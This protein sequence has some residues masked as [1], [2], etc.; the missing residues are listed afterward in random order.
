MISLTNLNAMRSAAAMADSNADIK[1]SMERLSTGS[2]INSA[3]DDAAGLAIATEMNTQIVGMAK[4]IDN[5]ADGANLMSTADGALNEVNSLLQRMRELAMQAANGTQSD[6]DLSSLNDEYQ[7][8]KS[9]IARIGANTEWNGKKIFDGIGFPGETKFQVGADAGQTIGVI[10]DK[11]AISEL[12]KVAGSALVTHPSTPPAAETTQETFVAHSA[13]APAAQSTAGKKA[14]M[15]SDFDGDGDADILT[16][17]GS[18]SDYIGTAFLANDG[19]GSFSV[20]STHLPTHFMNFG[21]PDVAI[22]IADFDGDGDVDYVTR[23]T[24]TR[25]FVTYLN[26]GA[27]N[28]TEGVQTSIPFDNY[29]WHETLDI[30][31]TDI[32]LDGDADVVT[33]D[34]IDANFSIYLNDGAGNFT[35]DRD[36]ATPTKATNGGVGGVALVAGDVDGDGDIDVV[37]LD[38]QAPHS[39]QVFLNDGNRNFSRH[40]NYLEGVG[41]TE[42]GVDLGDVDGDGDLDLVTRTHRNNNNANSDMEHNFRILLNDGTG[43]FSLHTTYDTRGEMHLRHAGVAIFDAD[44]DGDNDLAFRSGDATGRYSDVFVYK[45]DGTANF[46]LHET[47]YGGPQWQTAADIVAKSVT[48]AS[49]ST[50]AFDFSSLSLSVGDK[51]AVAVPGGTNVSAIMDSNGLAT[52]LSSLGN[53]LAAQ[54]SL[55]SGA[56]NAGGVLTVSGLTDGSA[57]PT[58]SVSLEAGVDTTRFDFNGKNLEEGDQI[59]VNVSGGTDVQGSLDSNGLDHLLGTLAT[60]L[61][62]QGSLFSNAFVSNGVLGLTGLTDG[63]AITTVTVSLNTASMPIESTNLSNYSNATTTLGN[64]DQAIE[65]VSRMRAKYGATFNQLFAA[66][67]NLTTVSANTSNSRSEIEDADYAKESSNLASAQIRNQGAKAM[68]AQANTD[69][70][71]TLSLLEDWL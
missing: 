41:G 65:D 39:I 35:F 45:N 42:I 40:D 24:Y 9:E 67:N 37:T 18:K 28:F 17:D 46:S 20:A 48:P 10:I 19:T 38:D 61:Q 31:A 22:D 50:S 68:L 34:G 11:L 71:L 23:D 60:Q 26:D 54:S 5:A 62:A 27:G 25:Y 6:G 66:I 21:A 3:S 59:V 29:R 30:V 63:S 16:R 53:D 47:G 7:S 32:D 14:S 51:V 15:G 49:A 55:F 52:L 12:G 4:A 43:N 70:Q 57:M 13:S 1:T 36:I 44:S 56:S 8:M 64:V 69:Q 33:R 2:R 58:L